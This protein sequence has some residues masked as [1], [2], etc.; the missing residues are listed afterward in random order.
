[1]A[2][3]IA[4]AGFT[5]IDMERFWRQTRSQVE[6][7]GD[8]VADQAGP[9]RTRGPEVREPA[10]HRLVQVAR[11]LRPDLPAH[12]RGEGP[13]GGGGVGRQPRPGRG[14]GRPDA[15]HH[16]HGLHARGRPDPQG[17]RHQ[18]L[19]RPGRLRGSLPRG[20]AGRRA[21]LR[22]GDRGGAHPPLRPPRRDARS[23]HGGPG[24]PRA[25]ARR[26]HRARAAPA[27]EGCWPASRSRSRRRRPDV[28]VVG[29]AGRG[30]RGVPRLAR[31]RA[32]PWS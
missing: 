26:R 25:G 18:G 14:A 15:R 17:A 7:I 6:A 1:M 19:R 21:T 29:R 24:D 30:R 27:G 22:R 10:A 12:R 16:V 9:A 4:A 28:R 2:S 32:S 3:L 31:A 5:W 20:V 13:G 11:G 23:G 8:I